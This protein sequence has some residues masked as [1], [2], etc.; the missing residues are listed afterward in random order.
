VSPDSAISTY[1]KCLRTVL[2]VFVGV[3]PHAVLGKRARGILKASKRRAIAAPE[4][5]VSAKNG[6]SMESMNKVDRYR[7]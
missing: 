2:F 7:H 6:G 5:Q 3:H 4:P 1:D